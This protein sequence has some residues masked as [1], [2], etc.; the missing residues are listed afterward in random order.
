MIV[1]QLLSAPALLLRQAFPPVIGIGSFSVAV[2]Y[3][4]LSAMLIGTSLSLPVMISFVFAWSPKRLSWRLAFLVLLLFATCAFVVTSL[5]FKNLISSGRFLPYVLQELALLMLLVA[6]AGFGA[7]IA[8]LLMRAY[9]GWTADQGS[10]TQT[11][12]QAQRR[13]DW[14]VL[15]C[16]AAVTFTAPTLFGNWNNEAGIGLGTIG[17]FAGIAIGTFFLLP[18]FWLMRETSTKTFGIVLT[19]VAVIYFVIP[20]IGIWL[21]DFS[22]LPLLVAGSGNLFLGLLTA[23]VVLMVQLFLFRSMGFRVR[24]MPFEKPAVVKMKKAVV[25]PFSD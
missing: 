22:R 2:D 11:I 13:T 19:L 18:A 16:I 24:K 21:A 14:L 25:D 4:Y 3:R 20:A 15:I 17:A 5:L 7:T 23:S 1:I 12:S 10:N 6:I 8:P 9:R